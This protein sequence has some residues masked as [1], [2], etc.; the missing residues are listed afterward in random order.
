PLRE[1]V[2]RAALAE[3]VVLDDDQVRAVEVALGGGLVVVT[4]GPGTGKTTL[5]RVLI[6]AV[7]ERA[8]VWRLASPT[9]RAARRLEEATGVTASTLHRLLEYD[10]SMGG[11]GRQSGHPIEGDGLVVDEASMVDLRLM[12]AL[13]A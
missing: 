6:R 5:V 7:R 10:P 4:G 9:G 12:A 8:E 3:G 11:F 2:V 1:E 13:L